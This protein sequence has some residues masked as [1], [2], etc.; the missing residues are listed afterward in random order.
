M[1]LETG[2]N[3]TVKDI[4][5]AVDFLTHRKT[6]RLIR[7]LDY[8]A[9]FCLMALWVAVS[10]Q[11]PD[12]KLT[13]WDEDDIEGMAKWDGDKGVFLN[14]LLSPE[15]KFLVKRGKVYC[16]HEWK[17]HNPWAA[18]SEKRSKQASMAALSRVRKPKDN[19]GGLRPETP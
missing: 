7:E 12:G 18:N 19:P 13:G 9:F 5:I 2:I 14:A 16:V 17:K 8:K 11:R 10:Q 1:I 4:R 3:M 6:K 15:I